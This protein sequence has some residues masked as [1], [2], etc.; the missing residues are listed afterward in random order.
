MGR[1]PCCQ[2][3]GLKRGRWTSQE[4]ETLITYIQA[5]GEG[6][7]KSLPKKAG[8]LRCGKS[9]R[10]RWINYLRGDLKRG[11]FSQ[12]E[13][14]MIVKLHTTFGNRW[15]MIAS[16]LPGRTDNEIKNHWNSHLSRQIYRFITSKNDKTP[17]SIDIATLDNQ[18]KPRV[19]RVSRC[20]A[21]K[22]NKNRVFKNSKPTPQFTTNKSSPPT[23]VDGQGDHQNVGNCSISVRAN[24]KENLVYDINGISDELGLNGLA[25]QDDELIDINYFLE[26]EDMDSTKQI[27]IEYMKNMNEWNIDDI[28]DDQNLLR[29]N[30]SETKMF[31][32]DEINM[33]DEVDDML[34]WLWEGGNP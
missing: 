30:R 14:E 11:N 7:W 28:E 16:H 31:D 29:L 21:K 17:T 13:E 25:V 27:D 26:S 32:F 34:V 23:T 9:C 4:D 12:D 5:N 15:S 22:Y 10:L 19:G 2:K 18:K 3:V 20:V 8:L 6:S 33:Y 24:I 1:A